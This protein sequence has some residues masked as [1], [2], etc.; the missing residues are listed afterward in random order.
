MPLLNELSREEKVLL[1]RLALASASET[2]GSEAKT[3]RINALRDG[4]FS[5]DEDHLSWD[6]EG[7]EQFSGA[8]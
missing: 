7:G 4:E 8:G 5:S 1:A 3:Y 2:L 6:A